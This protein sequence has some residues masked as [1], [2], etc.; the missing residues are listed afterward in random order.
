MRI[1]GWEDGKVL[2]ALDFRKGEP[3]I[4]DGKKGWF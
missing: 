1:K 3:R 4:G 2:I